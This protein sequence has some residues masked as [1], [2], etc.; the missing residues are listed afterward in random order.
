MVDGRMSLPRWARIART[1]LG[2]V[3]GDNAHLGC[4]KRAQ[5]WKHFI[6]AG[7]ELRLGGA[8]GALRWRLRRRWIADR[9]TG[10]ASDGLVA[11]AVTA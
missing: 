7:E 9:C 5:Q 10:A 4:A 3:K 1:V 2:S 8:D 11:I 6:D